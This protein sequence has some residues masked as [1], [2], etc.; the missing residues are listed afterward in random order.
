MKKLL[1]FMTSVFVCFSVVTA[2][3][4][5]T[6]FDYQNVDHKLLNQH[7]LKEVNKLRK[8]Q[9]VTFLEVHTSLNDAAADHAIYM[10]N[11]YRIGHKQRDKAKKWPNNRLSYYGAR[12][13]RVGENVQVSNLNLSS[14][15]KDRRN[16]K[17]TTYEKLA[18]TLVL[19]WKSSPE[20]YA[21]MINPDFSTTF[22]AIS[23]NS[24]GEV[25]ACQLLAGKEYQDPYASKNPVVNYKPY[26]PLRCFGCIKKPI[27]GGLF[28]TEDSTIIYFAFRKKETGLRWKNRW[29]DGIAADIVLKSQFDCEEGNYTNDRVGITGIPLA[30]VYRKDF[31]KRGR[32]RRRGV[33]IELGKVPDYIDEP[34]EVNLSFIKRNTPCKSVVY[35]KFSSGYEVAIPI[36]YNL[37]SLSNKQAIRSIKEKVFEFNYPKNESQISAVTFDELKS[38]VLQNLSDIVSINTVSEASIEG[39]EVEN[40]ALY[41]DRLRQILDALDKVGYDTSKVIYQ[42]DDNL[43]AFKEAIRDTKYSDLLALDFKD[44]KKRLLDKKLQAELEPI[45]KNHRKVNVSIQYY[46]TEEKSYDKDLLYSEMKNAIANEEKETIVKLQKIEYGM[47]LK[48]LLALDDVKALKIPR[49]K[50]NLSFLHNQAVLI[51]LMDSLNVDREYQLRNELESLLAFKEKD[52]WLNTSLLILDYNTVLNAPLKE[53]KRFFKEASKERKYVDK[54]MRARVV[55]S[56]AATHD[57]E[58]FRYKMSKSGDLLYDDAKKFIRDA[59]L[60]IDEVFSLASYY[61]FF[62]DFKFAYELTNRMTS[63]TEN[64]DHLVFFLKLIMLDDTGV[65]RKKYLSYYKR[66]RDLMGEGFCDLFNSPGLNFQVLIDNEVKEIYC[67]S[68]NTDI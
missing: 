52:K 68:C 25:F 30:P 11:T 15:P 47:M 2:Q 45:L 42:F 41:K 37:D 40:E 24:E 6:P 3:K 14:S 51:Y 62:E 36:S 46:E 32:W 64:P 12:F 67:E 5:N 28:L 9:K 31:R 23:I 55:L 53:K 39:G 8:K 13:D 54:T 44:L 19:A 1:S 59:K 27:G 60:E 29:T 43:A 65:S 56:L 61:T 57:W 7:I 26:S 33:W 18:E 20:H 21:N 66:I 49:S 58:N 16:P 50:Q 35:H 34:F 48:G 22:T 38:F 10:K 17:I 4:T 63:K